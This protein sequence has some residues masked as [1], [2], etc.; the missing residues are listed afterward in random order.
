MDETEWHIPIPL[1]P[2]PERCAFDLDR[3]LG[4]VVGVKSVV[5]SDAFTAATLGTERSGSGV[6]IREDGLVLTIG[7]VVTE[8]ELVWLTSPELGGV[9]AH[10][11]AVD[12]STGFG[13]VQ[14][15]RRL[16]V[17]PLEL[18]D[19]AA[20]EPGHSCVLASSGGPQ[21][22]VRTMVV[23]REPFAGYWEYLLENP[24][25]TSPPHPFWGGAG[26]IGD[27]GRLIGIGSLILQHKEPDG[28]QVDMNMVVPIELLTPI[29]DDMLAYGRSLGPARPWLGLFC[30]EN[31]GG[32]VV[33]SVSS[34]APADKAELRPGD[35]ILAVGK[36]EIGDLADLWRAVWHSG[37]AGTVINMTVRRGSGRFE[38][39]IS[40]ADRASFLKTPRLH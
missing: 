40:S 21:H 39:G 8:A 10:V 12:Q 32:V 14:A 34:G 1:R 31:S 5:P 22:A 33:Q 27:D 11:I 6:V 2:T 18:G 36:K 30:G 15:L 29:L 28:R 16:D 17:T 7:Y 13:L 19:S 35:R 9:P 4:A 3:A 38:T 20:I 25:F 26:L 37:P 24:I 23:G